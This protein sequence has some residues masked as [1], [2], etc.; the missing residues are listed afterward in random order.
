MVHNIADVTPA[1]ATV[2]LRPTRTPANWV[3]VI[4][5]SGNA[6]AIRLGDSTTGA[7]SGLALPA[8]SGMLFPPISDTQYL[9]LAM[10]YVYGTTTD[11]ISVVY[12][13]H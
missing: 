7:A 2:A 1:G 11:K 5:P 3:Q 12:G 9:D 13:T 6:A 8:G 4:C 10:I